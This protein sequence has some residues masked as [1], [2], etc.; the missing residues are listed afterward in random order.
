MNIG[1]EIFGRRS[2]LGLSQSEL[3]ALMKV[4]QAS[5]SRLESGKRDASVGE[6]FTL[7]SALRCAVGDLLGLPQSAGG[8]E[9]EVLSQLAAHGA[10]FIGAEPAAAAVR[11]PLESV[12]GAALPHLLEPRIFSACAALAA[13][14]PVDWD[15]LA[16]SAVR[17]GLQNRL[18]ALASF[19]D[20][21]HPVLKRLAASRLERREYF[22]PEPRTSEARAH[23]EQRTPAALKPWHVYGIP[24]ARRLSR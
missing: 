1:T 20:P 5:I 22:L 15:F 24:A 19:I 7:A 23:L 3:A 6:L 4:P 17:S 13:R 16:S 10:R 14:Q 8:S 11:L 12:L 18:G 21:E 2:A 9:E